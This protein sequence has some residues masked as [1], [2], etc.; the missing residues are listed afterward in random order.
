MHRNAIHP[1]SNLQLELRRELNS[2]DVKENVP[3][4]Q[5]VCFLYVKPPIL[6]Q[7]IDPPTPQEMERWIRVLYHM[8]KETIISFRKRKSP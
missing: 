7:K 3:I 6:P 8:N 5:M 4:Y 1:F 2:Q